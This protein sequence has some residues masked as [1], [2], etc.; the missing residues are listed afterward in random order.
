MNAWL[1][2]A[3]VLLFGLLPCIA[4]AIKG[5]PLTRLLGLEMGAM[6]AVLDMVLLTEWMGNVNF[7]DLPLCLALMSFGGSLVFIRFL[8]RWL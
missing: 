3:I 8:E 1:L 2:A 5:D 7:F 6:I 4:V